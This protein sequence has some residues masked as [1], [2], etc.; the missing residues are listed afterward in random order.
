MEIDINKIIKLAEANNASAQN[1]LG[2]A[3][4]T[5]NG[6]E[7]DDGK[8]L[9][10]FYR[11]ANQGNP[12]ALSN[13]GLCSLSGIGVSKD[14]KA[15]LYL[16]ESS[17]L[18]GCEDG[19]FQLLDA[20]NK[21]AL[22]IEDIIALSDEGDPHAEWITGYC[23]A[24]GYGVEKD[25]QKAMELYIKSGEKDNPIALWLL[26]RINAEQSEPDLQCAKE[27]MDKVINVAK[28]E[29]GGIGNKKIGEDYLKINNRYSN[30]N[31]FLLMKVITECNEKKKPKDQYVQDFLDGKLYMKSLDQFADITKRDASSDN[32]FRGDILEGYSE[33]FGK[34]YNPHAYMKDANGI[35]KDGILGQVDVLA[36]RKKVCCFTIIDYDPPKQ[37]F[38]FPSSKMKKFGSYAVIIKDVEEFIKRINIAFEKYKERDNASYRMAYNRVSYDVDLFGTFSYS[39]FHK[40]SSYS[41]QNE[42]RLSIDFSEGKFSQSILNG[43]TDFAKL[44]FKGNIE[45]DENPL[46]VSNWIYFEIGDIRDICE[47]V[48][49]NVLF[50]GAFSFDP[51][52]KRTPFVPYEPYQEPRPTFCKAVKAFR[53]SDEQ[54]YCL[55]VSA[56]AIYSDIL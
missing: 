43:V 19:L 35:V 39:E 13:L 34:G 36:L 52:I 27:Y 53:L 45:I 54:E 42:F 50:G 8:A 23:Y 9:I 48:D 2:V 4:L 16:F 5:G 25:P 14:L 26:A 21:K 33:S 41:W 29:V 22:N 56:E 44:T 6:V 49:I 51:A 46:S 12:E 38:T 32:D 3:Y 11:A 24:H 30:K 7:Q 31:G 15:A 28:K 40:T 37:A 47:C 18:M 1:I 10:W 55:G 20:I 17:F